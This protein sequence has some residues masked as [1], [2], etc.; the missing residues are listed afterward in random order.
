MKP[1]PLVSELV[2][3]DPDLA[4]LVEEFVAGLGQRVQR[5]CT[6]VEKADY[7]DLR[8]AAHQLKGSAGG[9]GYPALT[10]VAAKLETEAARKSLEQCR[11]TLA[12]IESL[13][14]RVV[15]RR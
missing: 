2:E 7:D 15:V 3:S 11:A 14:R 6:A 13:V 10:T 5:M 4:D 1:E 8:T 12:E 9:Y